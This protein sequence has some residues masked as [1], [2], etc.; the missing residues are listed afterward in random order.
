MSLESFKN[1]VREKPNLINYVK[2]GEMT[3]QK[4]YDIYE[5]YGSNNNIWDKYIEKSSIK[6]TSFKDI[7]TSLKN[8]DMNDLQKGIGSIQK[9]ITYIQ[10]IIKDKTIPEVRKD[11]YIPK[12]IYKHLDD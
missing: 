11:T 4:F 8:I 6:T 5:L 7:I 3:W 2:T 12:P 1:F 9:G 10:D